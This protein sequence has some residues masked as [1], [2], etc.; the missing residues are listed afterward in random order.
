MKGGLVFFFITVVTVLGVCHGGELR[1]HFYKKSCP[2]AEEIVKDII[3]K[4][5]ASN[6]T[7][8]AKFLRM[9][10]HDC[11]VRVMYI[12]L[13]KLCKHNVFGL[14]EVTTGLICLSGLRC[15]SL[16]RLYTKQ[17]SREGCTSESLPGRI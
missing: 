11:F 9:H 16:D 2:K 5:V 1:K 13:L 4:S 6:S 17:H 3:W 14:A 12:C 7:L 10:F 8:P 15:L